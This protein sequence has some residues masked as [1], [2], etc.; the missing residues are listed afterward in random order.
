[1]DWAKQSEEMVNNWTKIQKQ[2]METYF[3][4]M[5]EMTKSPSEKLWDTTVST[6][7]QAIKNTLSAQDEWVRSWID[8]LKSIE[9]LPK[10][11]LESAEQFQDMSK[12]W[13][14]TQ[15]QLWDSWFEMLK[16]LDMTKM[17]SSW[18]TASSSPFQAWQDST[19]KIMEAQ[20]EWMRAWVKTFG[21]ESDVE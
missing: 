6:G 17:T 10:Q 14:K 19:Q 11:A 15:G 1:M 2:L 7:K 9:G 18:G 12:N 20:A 16:K 5:S 13:L 4:S 21:G 3:E 8:Y